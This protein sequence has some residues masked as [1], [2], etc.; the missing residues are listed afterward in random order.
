MLRLERGL[1]ILENMKYI[2]IL[3]YVVF[4]L[5]LIYISLFAA[6]LTTKYPYPS[7]FMVPVFIIIYIMGIIGPILTVYFFG[8]KIHQIYNDNNH[9]S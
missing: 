7:D 4:G 2:K 9:K 3:L 6:L 1:L 5:T 8:Q